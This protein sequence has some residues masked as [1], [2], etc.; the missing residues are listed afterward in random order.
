[1]GYTRGP[2]GSRFGY[3]GQ[4]APAGL[5]LLEPR[6]RPCG[7]PEPPA[8]PFP[9]AQ[10]PLAPPRLLLSYPCQRPTQCLAYSRRLINVG[11]ILP[12]HSLLL[13]RFL[14][15]L[16]FSFDFSG[17]LPRLL[18]LFRG[19]RLCS[20]PPS[21]SRAFPLSTRQFPCPVF[22]LTVSPCLRLSPPPPRGSLHLSL[23][24]VCL[25]VSASF[26]LSLSPSFIRK[27]PARGHLGSRA[28]P[29]GPI[30]GPSGAPSSS[31]CP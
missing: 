30:F 11:L 23:V 19:L 17:F 27:F 18:F 6:V 26:S 15:L 25:G 29:A 9:Q 3:G 1:M 24:S 2:R 8:L 22:F 20:L 21:L 4:A 5:G 31:L 14:V 16:A 28:P 12:I 10:K 13:P 7:T